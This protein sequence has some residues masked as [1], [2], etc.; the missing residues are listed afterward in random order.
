MYFNQARALQWMDECGLDVLIATS[1]VNVTYFT[2]YACWIT[3]LLRDYMMSPGTSEHLSAM[4]AAFSRDERSCLVI[5]PMLA[6]NA[7]DVWVDDLC[8]YSASGYER[9][10]GAGSQFESDRRLYESLAASA[11]DESATDALVTW[12]KTHRLSDSRIGIEMAGL[13]PDA[14]DQLRRQLPDA[15]IMD[16]TNLI[17]IIRVVKT[18]TE[19]SLLRK[20][21]QI[22]EDACM[23]VLDSARP[24]TAIQELVQGYR[25]Q[26]AS[27][28]ADFDHYAYAVRGNGIAT[29]VD[30]T[31]TEGSYHFIDYGCIYQGYFSDTGL[32][33]AIGEPASH[34]IDEY[35]AL[36]DCH[37][38]AVA[39][40]RPGARSSTVANAM[41]AALADAG[42]TDEFPHGHGLGLEVRDYPIIVPDN[43]LR[44]AD[45]CIDLP[46]D[47][48][49]E[50]N[51]V[52]NLEIGIMRFGCGSTQYEQ[53]LLITADGCEQ[54][55][56]HDRSN[57]FVRGR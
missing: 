45:D 57:I 55:T 25:E 10:A 52:V 19:I 9:A 27:R 1:P 43:G 4:Y 41:H 47:L 37:E 13:R 22:S 12:L 29:R 14:A 49:L 21:A 42:I 16:C 38:R 56:P 48:P 5:D 33:L 26:I 17:R 30:Y 24:G 20:A 8:T 46:S 11:G 2:D 36:C 34:V 6:V 7:A 31:F 51:M 53:T 15:Q 35:E 39:Q 50:E 28:G 3:T 44:I 40:M 32:T 23:A 18:H 54:L